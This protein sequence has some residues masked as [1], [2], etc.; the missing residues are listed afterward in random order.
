[1]KSFFFIAGFL[2][3]PLAFAQQYLIDWHK[4]SGGGGASTNGQYSVAGTIGQPDAGAAMSGGNF[5]V[6]GGFW[7]L[8]SVIQTAGSPT[9]TVTHSGNSVKVSWPSAS[10]GF[11]LQQ[12]SD[13]SAASWTTSGYSISDDGTNKSI[14][15]TS[16][17]ENLFFRLKQ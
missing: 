3:S 9:L 13:L 12:N 6:T 14:T 2:F 4:I 8:I 17:T 1:M 5:S 16:P 10:T 11:V 7:S 15:I